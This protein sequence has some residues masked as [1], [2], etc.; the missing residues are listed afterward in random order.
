MKYFVV[1]DVHGFYDEMITALNKAGFDETNPD[2]MLISLGDALDRGK[3]PREVLQYFNR[4]RANNKAVLIKGNHEDLMRDMLNKSYPERHDFSNKTFATAIELSDKQ[5]I[6]NYHHLFGQIKKD[7]DWKEYC[8]YLVDYFETEHYV[9]VHGWIPMVMMN[10]SGPLY[11][12]WAPT[13]VRADWRDGTQDDWEE[14]RWLNGAKMS[15]SGF[16]IDKAIVCGHIHCSAWHTLFENKKEFTDF[17]PYKSERV[18]ALDACTAYSGFC[19]C[20]VLED[21]MVSISFIIA[22]W[23]IA[24]PLW[25][26]ILMTV[27]GAVSILF[28][29]STFVV[30][31]LVAARKNDSKTIDNFVETQTEAEK[32]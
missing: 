26:S 22:A 14:A 20:V 28:N 8:G 3:K 15:K 19:N 23:N 11:P 21:Q 16:Y 10:I 25:L 4:L 1:S 2:H 32:K 17:T 24:M 30:S 31:F 29:V 18:I 27:S 7:K 5:D 6:L 12:H 13:K 9:F